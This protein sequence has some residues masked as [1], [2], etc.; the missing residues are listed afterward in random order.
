MHYLFLKYTAFVTADSTFFEK[1]TLM[2]ACVA[3][4]GLLFDREPACQRLCIATS[5]SFDLFLY[6]LPFLQLHTYQVTC[7]MSLDVA[8]T[9][10]APFEGPF[11]NSTSSG[12]TGYMLFKEETTAAAKAS[13]KIGR[14]HV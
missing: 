3:L 9:L 12:K 10:L 14:A 4:S 8:A 13:S 2:L 5:F 11:S 7:P 1:S 6:I